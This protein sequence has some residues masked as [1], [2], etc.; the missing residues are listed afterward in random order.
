M[1]EPEFPNPDQNSFPAFLRGSR[2]TLLLIL[3][4]ALILRVVLA[5]WFPASAGDERRYTVPAIN[6]LHDHGFSSDLREP[7]TPTMAAVPLYPLFITAVFGIFGEHTLA[8][9]IAQGLLDL[10]TS[11]LVGFVSFSLAPTWLRRRAAISSVAIYGCLSW[12]TAF[13]TR[14]IL[15]E[16]LALFLTMLAIAVGIRAVKKGGWRWAIVGAICGLALMTRPDSLLLVVAFVLILAV[17]FV[18]HRSVLVVGQ[19]L[20]FSCALTATLAPWTLRNYLAFG[21]LQPLASEYGFATSRY[22]PIGYLRWIRTWITDETYFEV[23]EPAFGPGSRPFDPLK[24]PTD[25]FDSPEERAQVVQLMADYEKEQNFTAEMNDGF[26]AIANA[27]IHRAPLRFFVWLPLKRILSV[28][29]TGFA[30]T[31]PL[32]RLVR[33]LMVIPILVGGIVGLILCAR[34]RIVAGLLVLVV[35]T[36]IKI[37]GY[38]FEPESCYIVEAYPAIIAACGVTCAALWSH[39]NQRFRRDQVSPEKESARC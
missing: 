32:H 35:L 12:F 10:L 21:K 24:L 39:L 16:T 29:L 20:L 38:N 5:V 11:L 27:R 4:S 6:L 26:E 14:Y 30:T 2:K 9:R 22:M 33:M 15:T 28:W 36:R 13:W 23:F 37:L 8:V 7:Y 19:M 3:L 18:R 17:K 31:N 1:S 34:N 25:V